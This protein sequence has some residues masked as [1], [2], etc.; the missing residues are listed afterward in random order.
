MLTARI[1]TYHF[2]VV[3]QQ[4]FTIP[5]ARLCRMYSSRAW[6]LHVHGNA[7]RGAAYPGGR[8]TLGHLTDAIVAFP[9][10]TFARC[11]GWLPSPEQAHAGW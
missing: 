1:I 4:R 2:L 3:V 5:L 10:R 9:G 8:R 7:T 6:T 11:I